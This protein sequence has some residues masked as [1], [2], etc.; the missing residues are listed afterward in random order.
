MAIKKKDSFDTS[1]VRILI[2]VDNSK[3][4]IIIE[5]NKRVD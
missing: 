5:N 1:R 4:K 3:C 2:D